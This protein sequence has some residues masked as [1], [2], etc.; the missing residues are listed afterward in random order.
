MQT[1]MGTARVLLRSVI[2][3]S[4]GF[5]ISGHWRRYDRPPV[6]SGLPDKRTVTAPVDMSQ[7]AQTEKYATSGPARISGCQNIAPLW[8]QNQ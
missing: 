5:L 3:T 4:T 1:H 2:S 8:N 6:T 7:R